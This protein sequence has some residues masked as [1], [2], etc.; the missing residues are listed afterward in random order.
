M[1]KML[2]IITSAVIMMWIVS[3]HFS[4]KGMVAFSADNSSG[5]KAGYMGVTAFDGITFEFDG[6][7]IKNFHSNCVNLCILYF[8]K[9][10]LVS[11]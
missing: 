7:N 8:Y 4:A 3:V 9:D 11:L 6:D 5:L 1:K 10:I 2:S